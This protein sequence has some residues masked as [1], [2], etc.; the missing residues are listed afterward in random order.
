M[1]QDTIVHTACQWIGPEQ[2]PLRDHPIRYCGCKTLTGKSYCGEHYW[3]VYDKGTAIAGKRK[4][5]SIDAEIEELKRQQA[6][7]E[8]ENE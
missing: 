8:M 2:D 4:A 7:E 5:K 6:I 1:S 3:Q